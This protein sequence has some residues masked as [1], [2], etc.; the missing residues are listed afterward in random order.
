[1]TGQDPRRRGVA[2]PSRTMRPGARRRG[3]GIARCFARKGPPMRTVSLLL[4]MS[5][6]KRCLQAIPI[7]ARTHAAA[8]D[9]PVMMAVVVMLAVMMLPRVSGLREHH[10]SGRNGNR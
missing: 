5:N 4:A 6:R 8:G 10:R 3:F 1:M 2:S 7:A 9:Q